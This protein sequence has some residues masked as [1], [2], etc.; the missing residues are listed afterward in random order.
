MGSPPS[1]RRPA[2]RTADRA[3]VLCS[4]GT[5]ASAPAKAKDG[6][7]PPCQ[8]H[9]ALAYLPTVKAELVRRERRDFE[10][11]AILEFVIWRVPTP[12]PGS[13]HA[14]KY[15][16]YYGRD[17][18]RIVGYDN[19]RAKGD[20]RHLHGVETPYVFTDIDTLMNDFLN[21]VQTERSKTP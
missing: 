3:P 8:H 16:F 14:F 4:G 6:G 9:A 21:D 15:R 19:E 11:G 17:G 10:D 12:V 1:R 20:H 7:H 18:E 13:N 2:K 5:L